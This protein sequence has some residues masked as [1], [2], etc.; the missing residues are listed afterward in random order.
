MSIAQMDLNKKKGAPMNLHVISHSI[1]HRQIHDRAVPTGQR[2]SAT[3]G[4]GGRRL[5]PRGASPPPH[6]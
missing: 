6:R 1:P 5:V 3:T 2:R 4:G